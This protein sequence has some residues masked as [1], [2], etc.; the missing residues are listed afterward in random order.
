MKP[1]LEKTDYYLEVVNESFFLILT[2]GTLI[3]S[4]FVSD[5][6]ARKTIGWI[7]IGLLGSLIIFNIGFILIKMIIE[8]IHQCKLNKKRKIYQEEMKLKNL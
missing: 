6:Q 2:Y 8:K 1:Y 3:F 4:D 5:H 7:Y